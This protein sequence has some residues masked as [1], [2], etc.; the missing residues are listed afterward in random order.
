MK[1]R[2]PSIQLIKY[3]HMAPQD[4]ILWNQFLTEHG[5]EFTS[6]D[7]DVKVGEGIQPISQVPANMAKDFIEL[8]KKRIDAVGYKQDGVTIFEVKPRAGSTALGQLLTYQSLYKLTYPNNTILNLVLITSMLT[9]DEELLYN[10]YH[11]ISY[12]YP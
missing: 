5:K 6:F 1:G 7:Y 10:Q 8:T 4:Y 9:K 11:I 3:P 2:F 12:I